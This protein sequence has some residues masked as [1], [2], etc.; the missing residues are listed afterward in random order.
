MGGKIDTTW[1]VNSQVTEH[2]AIAISGSSQASTAFGAQ[3]YAVRVCC[4]GA[5]HYL[6]SHNG[7]SA[8]ANSAYLP[9][10]TPEIVACSPGD[11]VAVIRDA[12]A[13]GNFTVT[14]MTH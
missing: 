12:A 11:K 7:A 3:T 1:R 4:T 14:E 5:C 6:V 8:T 9:A 10:N 2:T 13:T